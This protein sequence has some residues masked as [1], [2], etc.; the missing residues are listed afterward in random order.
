MLC[1]SLPALLC[2][3]I[4]NL[5]V[6]LLLLLLITFP[7]YSGH[8]ALALVVKIETCVENVNKGCPLCI[9]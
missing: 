7:H 2:F 8:D 4:D 6:L 3:L 5:I 1:K 9:A